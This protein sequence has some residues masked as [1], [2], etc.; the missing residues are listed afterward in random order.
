MVPLVLPTS[1]TSSRA[2]R[3]LGRTQFNSPL[4][5]GSDSGEGNMVL[6][7]L[8]YWACLLRNVYRRPENII[9]PFLARLRTAQTHKLHKQTAVISQAST[10]CS[11]V[12]FLMFIDFT[13]LRHQAH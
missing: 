13:T 5:H 8:A 1:A 6:M 9:I 10:E 12:W 3:H 11:G 7:T 2:T 4:R